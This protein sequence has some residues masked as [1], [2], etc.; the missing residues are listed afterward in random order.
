[1]FHAYKHDEATTAFRNCANAA[2][3]LVHAVKQL[4]CIQEVT[5]LNPGRVTDCR[6]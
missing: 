2:F 5:G 1:M 6:N 3:D 4:A